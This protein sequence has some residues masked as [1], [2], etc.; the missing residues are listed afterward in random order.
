MAPSATG[1]ISGLTHNATPSTANSA[2]LDTATAGA[3]ARTATIGI[4]STEVGGSG[5]G[6]ISAGSQSVNLTGVVTAR[7]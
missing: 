2:S 1:S 4:T 3:R 5:L 6:T 7:T